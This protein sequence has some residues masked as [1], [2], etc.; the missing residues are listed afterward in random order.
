MP[1]KAI[2]GTPWYQILSNPQYAE[3]FNYIGAFIQERE[4]MIKDGDDDDGDGNSVEQSDMVM[5]LLNLS[6]IPDEVAQKFTF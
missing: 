6:S 5:L 2:Q 3:D 1:K 4:K